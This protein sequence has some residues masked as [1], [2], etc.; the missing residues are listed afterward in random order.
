MKHES[1]FGLGE[2]LIYNSVE[3]VSGRQSELREELVKVVAVIFRIGGETEYHCE[4]TGSNGALNRAAFCEKTLTG[5]PD[6]D[7]E[8]G[9][10]PNKCDEVSDGN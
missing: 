1:K 10:Y 5:D 8:K 4:W 7:Q 9:C 3:G 6:F 2:V